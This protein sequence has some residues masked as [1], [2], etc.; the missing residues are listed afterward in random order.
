[1]G[2]AFFI[3]RRHLRSKSSLGFVP[4]ITLISVLGVF[5]GVAALLVVLAVMNGFEQEVK[6]RII[7]TNAHV[8][9]LK[10]GNEPFVADE[11]LL[12]EV[13][14]TDGVVGA[15]PFVYTQAMIQ[16][17]EE[18]DG[19]AVKGIDPAGE[20]RVSELLSR[21]VPSDADLTWEP[22][23]PPPI[24]L[25]RELALDLGTLSGETVILASFQNTARN[26]FG[27]VPKMMR[28]RVAGFFD[29]GMYEYNANLA[30]VPIDAAR[31]FLGMGEK[32]TGVAIRV[33]DAYRAPIVADRILERVGA[34][35]FRANN[36]IHLNRTLFSWMSTEK[37]VMFVI[38]ALV[39]L[40]AA[41]NIAS[42]LIMVVM[43]KTREIG[44]LK[45][46]GAS[47]RGVLAVFVLEGAIIGAL[48][49]A[50]GLLGGWTVC[51]L[52][53]RYKFIPLPADV[54]FIDSLPVQMDPADFVRVAAAAMAICFAATLYPAWKASRLDPLQAIRYE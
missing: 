20:P 36:W 44:V 45:S 52:L 34:P 42:T 37:R 49:T 5:V 51:W 6:S 30:L 23:S 9:L 22:G 15:S 47:L 43:E 19:I 26:P 16:A 13:T 53:E 4:I 54:Y 48:G 14:E 41:F 11:E 17:G 24:L 1:M 40:V 38:L 2:Y 33:Q 50:L 8:I 3:A 18:Q 28:F 29:S 21:T 12:R 35:P 7:G 31:E 25:G 27:T 10:Y 46:M 32:V 39:I